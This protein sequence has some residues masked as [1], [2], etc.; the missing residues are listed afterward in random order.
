M[1]PAAYEI[2]C[3]K[4]GGK[5]EWS[6]FEGRVW[7]PKCKI[8]TAGNLGIFSGPV[9]IEVCQMLG[10]SFDRVDLKTEDRLYMKIKGDK[11]IWEK[12]K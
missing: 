4:C 12:R 6:E 3:D 9:P 7:C 10:M 11:L 2:C 5:V 1:Q 8:D